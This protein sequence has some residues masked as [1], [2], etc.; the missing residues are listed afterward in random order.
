MERDGLNAEIVCRCEEVTADEIMEAIRNGADSLE[1]VKKATRAGMGFC[2]GRTCK[3]LVA[4]MLACYY[5]MPVDRFLP[6]SLR[7]PV[8]PIRLD[9]LAETED[10]PFMTKEGAACEKS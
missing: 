5:N 2:Q 3:R 8:T 6:G 7:L 9:L 4:R 10:I 1:A